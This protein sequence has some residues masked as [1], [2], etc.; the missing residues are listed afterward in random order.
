MITLNISTISIMTPHNDSQHN[1][2]VHHNDSL[3]YDFQHNDY[4]FKLSLWVDLKSILFSYIK[5]V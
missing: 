2:I 1:D 3:H 5:L 4:S